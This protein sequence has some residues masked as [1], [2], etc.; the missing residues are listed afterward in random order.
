MRKK[1]KEIVGKT[2]KSPSYAFE[3]IFG[4]DCIG[5]VLKKCLNPNEVSESEITKLK[6]DLNTELCWIRINQDGN[7]VL[8]YDIQNIILQECGNWE[9]YEKEYGDA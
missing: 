6:Q 5:I 9:N 2:F 7:F 3:I 1:I 4:Y 8:C